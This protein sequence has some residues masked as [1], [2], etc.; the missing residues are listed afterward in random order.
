MGCCFSSFVCFLFLSFLGRVVGAGR[1]GTWINRTR[2][3]INMFLFFSCLPS[4]ERVEGEEEL[5]QETGEEEAPASPGKGQNADKE[6][7]SALIRIKL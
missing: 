4:A 1:G 3:V 6:F 7:I 2:T 5:L